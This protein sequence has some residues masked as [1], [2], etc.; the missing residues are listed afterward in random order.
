MPSASL[1][2][3]T[4]NGP[5]PS[6]HEV[7][8][9]YRR[10]FA[11]R[12][13]EGS[14]RPLVL[15]YVLYGYIALVVYLCV[16]HTQSPIIYAARWP[17]L[18][19]IICFHWK[20]LWEMSSANMAIA[21]VCG[22]W[23]VYGVI[24]SM[25][26]LVFYRPQFDA[27]RIQRRQKGPTRQ[28]GH[29][30]EGQQNYRIDPMGDVIQT[31]IPDDDELSRKLEDDN[32]LRKRIVVNGKEGYG[33]SKPNGVIQ[34]GT[35]GESISVEDE[36]YYWQPYPDTFVERFFWVMD[37]L[38]NFRGPGWSWAIP[39]LPE[40]PTS[41]KVQLE[42]PVSKISLS[43]KSSTGLRS[44][45]TR[46]ELFYGRVPRFVVGL[47]LLDI[48][49]TI[50]MKDPYFIFGPNS[51]A[52]PSHI[53]NLSHFHLQFYR[54]TVAAVAIVTSLEMAFLLAPL[55]LGLLFGPAFFGQRVEPWYFPTHWGSFSN[56]ADKGLNGLWGSWWHQIF[57]LAFSAPSNFLIA[58]GFVK[59]RSMSA[60]IAALLSAFG[61]SALL[62][63]GASITQPAKT[64]PSHAA[65]FFMLQALG[66]LIQTTACYFLRTSIDRMP[67]RLCQAGNVVFT[68]TWLFYTSSLLIDDFARG[69]VWLYEPLPVSPLRGLGF[70]IEGD[71][72]W[73]WH[74]TGLGWY[75][76]KHWWESG[77][78]I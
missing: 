19:V 2:T 43:R 49:K 46:S 47:V 17:V 6:Y 65:L 68:F 76:G 69:G 75:K 64:Y 31:K 4:S 24:G 54:T 63:T 78:A 14:L 36:E 7:S 34:S 41:I 35:Q 44:F 60:K 33:T 61:V 1:F 16:P 72:W 8:S 22:L 29:P 39:P 58:M 52:L 9:A 11:T 20:L 38:M 5:A 21:M 30:I 13:A 45:T 56:I 55:V 37:L 12:V 73:C 42:D 3:L 66:I 71:T 70:G 23:A 77:I 74:H 53:S 27:K 59:A 10:V 57:R 18:G 26:W 48:L 51:Y 67:K 28:N 62:H 50:M 40:I 15:P 25:T 32:L